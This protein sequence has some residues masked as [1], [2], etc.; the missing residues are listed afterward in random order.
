MGLNILQTLAGLYIGSVIGTLV[1]AIVGLIFVGSVNIAE[2]SPFYSVFGAFFAWLTYS[3]FGSFSSGVESAMTGASTGVI[4]GLITGFASGLISK[5]SLDKVFR[6]SSA[7]VGSAVGAAVFGVFILPD[8]TSTTDT[9]VSIA[10]GLLT[11][12]QPG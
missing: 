5:G 11:G 3:R 9:T 6:V 2:E 1:G 8:V 4:A 10:R 7:G 12:V